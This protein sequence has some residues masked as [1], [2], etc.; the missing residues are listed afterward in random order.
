MEDETD[1]G[2]NFEHDRHL[3]VVKD[4]GRLGRKFKKVCDGVFRSKKVRRT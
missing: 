2:L 4:K 3:Y 1:C